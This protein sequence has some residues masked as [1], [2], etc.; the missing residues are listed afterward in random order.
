MF[1]FDVD[2]EENLLFTVPLLFS[3]FRMSSNGKLEQV[4]NSG[5]SPGGFGIVAGIASDE[6]GF[7]YVTDR[8]RCVVMI[9]DQDFNFI[10]EFGHRGYRPA[11]LIVPDDVAVDRRGNIYVSQAG[12]RGVSVFKIHYD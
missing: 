11:N 10:T 1:G 4:G 7:Y 2:P 8:L 3:A 9:F 12:N 6:H 5:S